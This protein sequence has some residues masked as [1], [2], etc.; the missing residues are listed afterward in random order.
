MQVVRLH[1]AQGT[2]TLTRVHIGDAIREL[3]D[4]RP[5]VR[6]CEMTGINESRMSRLI[7]GIQE[8]RIA[9]VRL[10]ENA[11][12]LDVGELIRRAEEMSRPK[13][14]SLPTAASAEP[15]ARVARGKRRPRPRPAANS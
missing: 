14:R 3:L 9:E 10:I 13:L 2:V 8:I 12:G 4:G 1:D 7:N 15:G 5:H 6:L 11:Y